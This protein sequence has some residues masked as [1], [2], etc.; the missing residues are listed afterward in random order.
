MTY[1][2]KD[3]PVKKIQELKTRY[4]KNMGAEQVLFKGKDRAGCN[5]IKIWILNKNLDTFLKMY[6]FPNPHKHN[7]LYILSKSKVA[8]WLV[9]IDYR[10]NEVETMEALAERVCDLH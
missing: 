7:E 3:V 9:I 1:K 8:T 5:V 2:Y 10:A 4:Y 6:N